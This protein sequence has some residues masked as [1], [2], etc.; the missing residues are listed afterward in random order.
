MLIPIQNILTYCAV[1]L[2]A[3]ESAKF[4]TGFHYKVAFGVSSELVKVRPGSAAPAN[5][6]A[7][8]CLERK[9]HDAG[10]YHADDI[11][12]DDSLKRGN[13]IA[14]GAFTGQMKF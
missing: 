4:G 12:L 10:G 6:A 7:E 2:D 14:H 3:V 11:L 13:V 9:S 1:Q 5:V 8:T